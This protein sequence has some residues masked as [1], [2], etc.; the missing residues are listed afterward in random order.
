[1][2]NETT[3]RCAALTLAGLPCKNIK[4]EGTIFCSLI[5]HQKYKLQNDE[6]GKKPKIK[7]EVISKNPNW[8]K[9]QYIKIR[10]WLWRNQL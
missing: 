9:R 10:A 7:D 2:S 4:K 1:M 3:K 5:S 8:F 6:F